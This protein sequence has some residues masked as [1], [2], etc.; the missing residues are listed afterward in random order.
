MTAG[1]AQ[2]EQ[3]LTL[4]ARKL[5]L[6]EIDDTPEPT[7]GRLSVS[8]TV[9]TDV[10]EEQVQKG[11]VWM[12]E[13]N[14]NIFDATYEDIVAYFGV[15]GQFVKEEYSDH[16]KANYRYYKWIS[17][18]DDSHFIYVNF[19]E[20]VSG[21]YTVSGFNTSGFSGKEAIARYLAR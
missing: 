8:I 11:Y 1:E 2:Y 5:Y 12:N 19:K 7:S 4:E 18:D 9:S 14:N 21:V 13:V 15:E 6:I 16:M 10:T 20:T 3:E 17:E